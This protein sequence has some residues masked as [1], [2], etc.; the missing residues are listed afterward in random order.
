MITLLFQFYIPNKGLMVMLLMI[1][2]VKPP[3]DVV[4]EDAGGLELVGG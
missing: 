4:C 1:L 2:S 3:S